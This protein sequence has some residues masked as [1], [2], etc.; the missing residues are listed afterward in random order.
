MG[1]NTA[2]TSWNLKKSIGRIIL[3]IN[4]EIL[5]FLDEQKKVKPGV[6]L[7]Q[8]GEALKVEIIKKKEALE[9]TLNGVVQRQNYIAEEKLEKFVD[10]LK[11][12]IATAAKVLECT[13]DDSDNI[14]TEVNEAQKVANDTVEELRVS[15][16]QVEKEMKQIVS[17]LANMVATGD[18][19]HDTIDEE[20][21]E[22][23]QLERELKSIGKY[24]ADRYKMM[25]KEIEQKM[26]YHRLNLLSKWK[27]LK[28][29][30]DYQALKEIRSEF[31]A[32][33]KLMRYMVSDWE[34]RK[35]S[36]ILSD[37]LMDTIGVKCDEYLVEYRRMEEEK[38]LEAAL[39]RKRN[40]E[41]EEY[42][43]EKRRPVPSWPNNLPYSK[44]K[45][46]LE[47]WDAEHRL[48]SGSVKFGLLAEMLKT[49]GRIVTYE[50]LQVRLGN[51]R[52]DVDI[53][54]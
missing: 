38:R 19:T 23:K 8:K 1:E 33:H 24:Q 42:K 25:M 9:N 22:E 30:L 26:V 54:N 32:T 17:N 4:S 35:F 46:D 16:E 12:N 45:P 18:V 6:A 27:D 36:D 49:Q 34:R 3:S 50:Q 41:M 40:I 31:E 39:Q 15:E 5:Q 37:K 48:S 29:I 53:I 2:G 47:S 10:M 13:N 11:N 21:E 44:F 51:N 14:Q 7:S 52:N 43:R 28:E 20:S